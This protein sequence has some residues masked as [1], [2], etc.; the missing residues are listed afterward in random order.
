MTHS[1]DYDS[2]SYNKA[3]VIDVEDYGAKGDGRDDSEAFEKAWGVACSSSQPVTFMVANDTKYKLKPLT[4]QGPCKSN[5]KVMIEGSIE[6]SSDQSDWDGRD[7]RHW[8]L[9]NEI[10]DLEVGGGGTIDGN[11]NIWWQ[12]S[13]KIKTSL[14]CRDAPTAMTF[15]SCKNLK[16]NNLSIRN[17]QQIHVSFESC[18]NVHASQLSISS[19]E[20]SPNTDGIHVTGTQNI[21]ITNCVI[22]TGDDC[23]S[24]VGGSQGV[25][26]MSITC[27]P[28]HGISI[29][30]L[31]SDDSEAYVSDV[32]VDTATLTGTKNG[33]RIKTWQGG[34]GY[35]KRI[36][37]QNINMN[38]VENPIIIDQN[39]CDSK[40]PCGEQQSAVAVSDILYKN[41]KGTSASEIA[42]DFQCSKSVPCHGI[43]LQDIN[44][45]KE[46]G[47]TAKSSCKNV[48]WTKEAQALPEPCAANY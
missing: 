9:F 13:C 11:G 7:E 14:P 48:E 34:S 25:K 38:N 21:N 37:F 6:A 16:V 36:T 35:A 23:I 43:V 19:P 27:G 24:I 10:N 30:S 45:V 46:G 20:S 29:G 1:F 17:S 47:G 40:R 41:I 22:Q 44:L 42:V 2:S 31:G 39:Y 3:V 28:G 12:N 18:S 4:F 5:V 33:V 26:A 32:V 8:L 15:S